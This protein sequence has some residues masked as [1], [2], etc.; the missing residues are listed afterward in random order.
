MTKTWNKVPQTAQQEVP[1]SQPGHSPAP[2]PHSLTTPPPCTPPALPC[3]HQAPVSHGGGV[4][5]KVHLSS[6]QSVH[7]LQQLLHLAP[8]Q[9]KVAVLQRLAQLRRGSKAGGG[10][11]EGPG[12]RPGVQ[13]PHTGKEAGTS[14]REHSPACPCGARTHT[15]THTAHLSVGDPP[16][17]VCVHL[18]E[19]G[20][21]VGQRGVARHVAHQ[22]LERRLAEPARRGGVQG[23]SG[24][25]AMACTGSATRVPD[26]MKGGPH[27]LRAHAAGP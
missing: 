27:G 18:L 14:A 5:R 10:W 12:G 20:A 22:R 19:G 15:H 25:S 11:A 21:Q 13:Q 23:A 6:V 2:Q 8:R 9:R 17:V 1:P 3:P 26:K 7:L 4:L 24:E 16:V